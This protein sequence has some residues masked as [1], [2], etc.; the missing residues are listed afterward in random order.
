MRLHAVAQK[1]SGAYLPV[2]FRRRRRLGIGNIQPDRAPR[3]HNRKQQNKN[4][5]RHDNRGCRPDKNRKRKQRGKHALQQVNSVVRTEF[6][7]SPQNREKHIGDKRKNAVCHRADT[8]Q[9]RR[10][11]KVAV[12][13]DQ[14]HTRAD[15]QNNKRENDGH[16][17]DGSNDILELAAGDVVD[18]R[19]IDAEGEQRIQGAAHH[20]ILR[21]QAAFPRIQHRHNAKA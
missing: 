11:G 6:V 13:Q 15:R 5:A 10:I 14:D 19:R 17:L 2:I 1:L 8:I 4:T 16:A 9:K 7:L 3:Q 18:H 20:L 12:P 21:D